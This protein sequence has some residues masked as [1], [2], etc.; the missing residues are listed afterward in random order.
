MIRTTTN[1][2]RCLLFQASLPA[3]YWA[4]ALHAA[5]H[6][7]N[8]LPSKA[9]SHATPYFTLYGTA[10]SYALLRVFGCV[11]Y[12]NTSATAP[13]KLSP[14]STR[15][16]F[17]GYSPNHKGYCCLELTSNRI[18]IS[19]HDVFDEDVFPLANSPHPLTSTPSLSLIR[20]PVPL[21]TSPRTV[22][23]ATRGF[24]VFACCSIGLDAPAH[25]S[26]RTMCGHVACAS[27]SRGTTDPTCASRSPVD[28]ACSTLCP[29]NPVCATCGHTDPGPDNV[30]EPLCRPRPHLLPPRAR[31]SLS[32]RGPGPL[33]ER[34]PIH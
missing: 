21:G 11:C 2:I 3:R 7:L 6:L 1:M 5:T 34:G 19:R 17:L 13:H 31:A 15:C 29:V 8:R 14:R 22:A 4:E 23:C 27:T 9:V 33:D 18:I 25:N 12:P 28:S 30:W 24:T 32:D 16:L 10:P 20:V 26:S